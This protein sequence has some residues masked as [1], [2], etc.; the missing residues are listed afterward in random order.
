MQGD[1]AVVPK[2]SQL[3]QVIGLVQIAVKNI[4]KPSAVSC[5]VLIARET[6]AIGRQESRA[7]RVPILDSKAVEKWY[8]RELFASFFNFFP[9]YRHIN[10]PLLLTDRTFGNFCVFAC[11]SNAIIDAAVN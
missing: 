9:P 7:V 1:V 11:K 2:Q 3:I 6:L 10:I 4:T 8:I 5:I